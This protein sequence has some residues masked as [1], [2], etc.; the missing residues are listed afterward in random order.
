MGLARNLNLVC[1][2]ARL[3][4]AV[5]GRARRVDAT[6]GEGHTM[7]ST[8]GYPLDQRGRAAPSRRR[9]SMISRARTGAK[10]A[11]NFWSKVSNDWVF[12]LSGMLAYNILM[13]L[14][15]I[16]LVLLAVAGFI[17]GA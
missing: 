16:L 15:P 3:N 7:A 11:L 8:A 5:T 9:E 2:R 10:P 4:W 12:N 17:L 13:S 1:R 14:F 6:R